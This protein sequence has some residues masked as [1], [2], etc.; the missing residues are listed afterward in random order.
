MTAPRKEATANHV[1]EQAL[2]DKAAHERDN[3]DIVQQLRADSDIIEYKAYSHSSPGEIEHSLTITTLRGPDKII[4]PPLMFFNTS[5]T[6][7][8]TVLHLGKKL[9]GHEGIIHGGLAATIL[10]ETLCYLGYPALAPNKV[11]FTANLNINYR[12]PILSNQWVV[13]KAK[14]DKKEEYKAHVS[15]SIRSLKE[16]A[17]LTE[18]TCLLIAPKPKKTTAASDAE[19]TVSS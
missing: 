10:D 7:L 5:Y 15:A 3:L 6:E 19:S 4:V 12:K 1:H 11:V 17:L 16:D 13:I 14:L 8:T 9:C 18:A 2:I